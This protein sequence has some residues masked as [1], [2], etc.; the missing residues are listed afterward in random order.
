MRSV[1]QEIVDESRD[2]DRPCHICVFG[3]MGHGKS[4]LMNLLITSVGNPPKGPSSHQQI[5]KV[6]VE[7]HIRD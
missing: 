4:R 1:L 2:T 7:V 6:K 3:L 5:E